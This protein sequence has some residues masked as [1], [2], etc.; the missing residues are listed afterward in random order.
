MMSVSLTLIRL[1]VSVCCGDAA[2]CV[3][4]LVMSSVR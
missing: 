3:H 1:H 4:S 2:L